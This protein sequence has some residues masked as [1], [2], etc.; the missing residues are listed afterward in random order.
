MA[1][2]TTG[3]ST[4]A[5][6][7]VAQSLTNVFEFGVSRILA[8]SA[9]SANVNL[10]STCRFIS[11]I[12]TAGTHIHFKIGVGAQTA[13]STSHILLLNE[14]LTIAVPPDANIGAIQGSLAGNLYISELTQ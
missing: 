9:T 5:G 13:T 14:R 6:A 10:T 1:S 2:I 4:T 3:G 12:S 8:V 11:I 7:S